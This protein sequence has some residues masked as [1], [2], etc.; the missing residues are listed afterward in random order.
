MANIKTAISIDKSLFEQVDDL[1]HELNTSRSRIF[2]LAAT[3]FIQRHKNIK[4]LEAINA[5]YDDFPDV[6]E[7]SLR[8][9]M[10]SRHL[11]M[12]KDQW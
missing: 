9:A 3:E 8:S 7:A 12:V 2:A 4:L 6:K 1:A 5:A 11:K 10:R